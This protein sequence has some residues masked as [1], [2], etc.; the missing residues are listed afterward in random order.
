MKSFQRIF[1]LQYKL[2]SIFFFI[3]ASFIMQ[4]PTETH[5]VY[6]ASTPTIDPS[7][8][9]FQYNSLSLL[10]SPYS[11]QFTSLSFTNSLTYG[12]HPEFDTWALHTNYSNNNKSISPHD[13][14]SKSS[15]KTNSSFIGISSSS[16]YVPSNTSN[17]SLIQ[18]TDPPSN[19]SPG[20][21][22][23]KGDNWWKV[24]D[25]D[26]WYL[27]GSEWYL[28]PIYN[29][30]DFTQTWDPTQ[31]QGDACIWAALLAAACWGPTLWKTDPL[32]A[33]EW[34]G[35]PKDPDNDWWCNAQELKSKQDKLLFKKFMNFNYLYKK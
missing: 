26:F 16:S 5:W 7:P 6:K 19:L 2:K 31:T 18:K 35:I 23:K 3:V 15:S 17:L 30:S 34:K 28:N 29:T 25:C 9:P 10:S 20:C 13:L 24:T 4:T 1:L 12:I 8:S 33:M 11:E 21:V 32:V 22:I 27:L 14:S